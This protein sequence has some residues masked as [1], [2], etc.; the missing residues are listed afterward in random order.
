MLS[1]LEKQTRN[2]Q[3]LTQW[4]FETPCIVVLLVDLILPY[5]PSLD[6]RI[7][8]ISPPK[9]TEERDDWKTKL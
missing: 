5:P 7:L 3:G 6:F 1:L 2:P 8:E 9:L 4:M